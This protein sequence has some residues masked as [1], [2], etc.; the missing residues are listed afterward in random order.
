M[1]NTLQVP[2]SDSEDDIVAAALSS[3]SKKK[4]NT[5]ASPVIDVVDLKMNAAANKAALKVYLADA[6]RQ[7]W[8]TSV[9]DEML[10]TKQAAEEKKTQAVRTA[11]EELSFNDDDFIMDDVV[12]G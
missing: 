1:T 3:S 5:F 11:L 12:S 9:I 4:N 6:K 2:Y 10:V 8:V 7:V